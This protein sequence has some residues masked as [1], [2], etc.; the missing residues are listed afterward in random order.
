MGTLEHYRTVI[1]AVVTRWAES[2]QHNPIPNI[3]ICPVIDELHDHYLLMD[4]GWQGEHRVLNTMLN[5]RLKEGKVWIE[6]DWTKDGITAE[7]IAGGIPAE[8]IVP[9]FHSPYLRQATEY[10]LA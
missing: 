5:L 9:A 4:I 2:G 10:T 8:D 6:E 7:L 1:K 3:E